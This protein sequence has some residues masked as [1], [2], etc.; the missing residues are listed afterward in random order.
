VKALQE[1]KRQAMKKAME[2]FRA[3]MEKARR[4]LKAVLKDGNATSAPANFSNEP[5][6]T[7]SSE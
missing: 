4:E 2:E 3:A 5:A 6:T 1:A 7:S